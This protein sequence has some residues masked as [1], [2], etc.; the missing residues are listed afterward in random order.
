MCIRVTIKLLPKWILKWTFIM[1][2]SDASS[3]SDRE[4]ASDNEEEYPKNK[5][6][7]QKY[8]CKACNISFSRNYN[9]LRHKK[10]V[11]FNESSSDEDS[12]EHS[13]DEGESE[14]SSD[15]DMDDDDYSTL[16]NDSE[17][18]ERVEKHKKYP[19][20][21]FS[22]VVN[23]VFRA[24]E[25]ELSP[26]IQEAIENGMSERKA[27]I[28]ALLISKPAKKLL[29]RL[30]ADSIIACIDERYAP[31]HQ[32]VLRKACNILKCKYG[33]H[34]KIFEAVP[35]AVDYH[36]EAIYNMVRFTNPASADEQGEFA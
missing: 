10:N 11:H 30:Y 27:K 24:Y 33:C 6:S 1:S 28:H 21:M 12:S 9:L 8:W 14:R 19:S 36:K 2:D 4:F 25:N 17:H 5:S 3:I 13:S 32:T 20:Y 15:E 35:D 26:S 22:D 31:L 23:T 16:G 29:R 18:E 7:H 34:S